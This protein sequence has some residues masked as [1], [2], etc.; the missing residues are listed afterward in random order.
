MS[1]WRDM[2][3]EG[4][5]VIVSDC[6]VSVPAGP[7]SVMGNAGQVCEPTLTSVSS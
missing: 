4:A 7:P 2:E 5:W 1:W 6:T 3:S